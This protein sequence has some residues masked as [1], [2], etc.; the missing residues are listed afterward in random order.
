MTEYLNDSG[1][2][3]IYKPVFG[4]TLNIPGVEWLVEHVVK[5]KHSTHI[6]DPPHIPGIE[7]HGT[8]YGNISRPC[9]SCQRS[10]LAPT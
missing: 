8:F 4:N 1:T 2:N 5:K 9:E 7:W 10:G 6:G 3:F